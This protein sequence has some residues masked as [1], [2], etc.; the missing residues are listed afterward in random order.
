MAS[1][2]ASR[3]G[4]A[5]GRIKSAATTLFS[6]NQSLLAEIR[7]VVTMMKDVGVDLERENESQMVKEL[8]DGVLQ[9][10]AASED[11]THLS[12]AIQS[13]GNGYQ[14]REEATDFTKLFDDEIA[15]SKANSSSVPQNHMLLRQFR[16]AIWRVHHAGQPMPGEEQE[17]LVMTST[18]SNIL[19]VNCPLTGKPITELENPVR[20]LDCK[21]IY[22]QNA[23]MQYIRSKHA[24]SQCPVAGCPKILV[25]ERVVCDP[26]LLV[27]IEEMSL[28]NKQSARPDVVEDFT[29]TDDEESG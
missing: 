28:L 10:L 25:A 29:A 9:L 17:D 26:L 1:T 16:E 21:H 11:C 2:S 14:P 7:K 22:E 12:T 20:S 23:I 27:E 13:V 8:E 6:D 3:S 5:A 15:K 19:N 4:G 24:H 18:Q